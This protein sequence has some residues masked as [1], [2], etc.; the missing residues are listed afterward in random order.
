MAGDLPYRELR[1][2]AKRLENKLEKLPGV[3]R[4]DRFGFLDREIKVEIQ[5]QKIKDYEMPLREVIGAIHSRNIRATG[6]NLESYT[7]EKN[8]VTLAQ[9]RDPM[10]VGD[11]IVRAELAG[12]TIKVSDIAHIKDDFEEA[13]TKSKINGRPAISFYVYKNEKADIVETIDSIKSL[14]KDMEGHLKE[15]GVDILHALD[16]SRYVRNR[17]GIVISNG[18]IGLLLVVVVLATFLNFRSAIW[19]AMGIPVTILATIFLLPL[20][21]VLLG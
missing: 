7:S 5:P 4:L 15:Q 21:D 8:V 6:G 14:A 20:F 3:S 10:E 2:Y 18:L 17:F 1:E 19:V 12:P 9:F 11:V 13:I 16:T